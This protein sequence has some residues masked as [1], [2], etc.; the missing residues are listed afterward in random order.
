MADQ[1]TFTDP[2]TQYR[3]DGFPEQH[4]DGTGLDEDLQ[5]T[6]DHGEKTYRGTGRLTG[7]KCAD[8]HRG[9]TTAGRPLRGRRDR[10]RTA[11]R[12]GLGQLCGPLSSS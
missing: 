9:A 5:V 2:T 11:L 1:Y 3:A 7:R 4:Q 6:A 8:R 10:R 12:G